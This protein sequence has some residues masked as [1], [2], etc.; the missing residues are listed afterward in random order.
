M[1]WSI[2]YILL[3]KKGIIGADQ[4]DVWLTLPWSFSLI[5]TLY[6]LWAFSLSHHSMLTKIIASVWWFIVLVRKTPSEQY[7]FYNS[8]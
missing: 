2:F 1:C 5:L 4:A 8:I 7:H 3:E 6:E